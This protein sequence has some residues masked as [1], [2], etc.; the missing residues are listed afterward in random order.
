MHRLRACG[1]RLDQPVRWG[2][3]RRLEPFSRHFGRE[4]GTPIDRVY[5]EEFFTEHAADI[6]GKVLEVRDP[7]YA[8]AH[9]YD[10]TAVDLIDIDSRNIEATIVADLGVPDALPTA[11]FTCAIVPQTL[12]YVGDPAIAIDNLWRC[13]EPGGVLLITVPALS[14]VERGT[15]HADAWRMLV[16]GL[17][18]LLEAGCPAAEPEVVGYGNLLATIAMMLGIAAEELRAD[19]LAPCD[20]EYPIVVCGRVRKPMT[21]D[22]R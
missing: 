12:Q 20:P 18:R 19:E 22:S 3:V 7:Q 4:R 2:N 5:L 6:C 8:T 11:A 13:L 16:P 15:R 1:R 14:R 21:D 9:G 17:R 10:I